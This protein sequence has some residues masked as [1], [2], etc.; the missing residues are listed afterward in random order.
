M[1]LGGNTAHLGRAHPCAGSAASKCAPPTAQAWTSA[2]PSIRFLRPPI[3]TATVLK[4]GSTA[5]TQS[6]P[7]TTPRSICWR[8]FSLVGGMAESRPDDAR[9]SLEAL[10]VAY[11]DM[12]PLSTFQ[13]VEDWQSDD[14]GLTPIQL[15]MN[16]AIP[17]LDSAAEPR[18]SLAEAPRATASW[19]W[20]GRSKSWPPTGLPGGWRSIAGQC[21]EKHWGVVL[22]NFPPN[23]AH[24]HRRLSRRLRQPP[25]SAQR[26]APGR[27]R[28]GGDLPADV[29]DCAPEIVEGNSFLF[30]TDGNVKRI[31]PWTTTPP[32]LPRLRGDGEILGLRTGELLNDGKRFHILGKQYGNIFVGIQPSFGF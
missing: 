30:G 25:P 3:T 26:P 22:F 18:W 27:L 4:A 5:T 15:T 23:L 32:L 21:R 12:I 10:D 11:L 24:R 14:M 20:T 16:I 13:R 7:A 29:K 28:P 1:I 31:W 2:R 9:D 8:G 19:R 17:E 6:S